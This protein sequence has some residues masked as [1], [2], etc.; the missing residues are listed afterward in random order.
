MNK[1]WCETQWPEPSNSCEP[2]ILG[3]YLLPYPPD[4]Y[5]N[6]PP[7]LVDEEAADM[8]SRPVV[9]AQPEI[10]ADRPSRVDHGVDTH[11][12]LAMTGS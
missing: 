3:S 12:G 11:G 2:N 6:P 1:N 9:V 10:C 4:I 5:V 8:P 7:S